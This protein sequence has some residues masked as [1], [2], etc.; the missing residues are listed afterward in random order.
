MNAV[1]LIFELLLSMIYPSYYFT[2]N[3]CC[4]T[5]SRINFISNI[6][7]VFRRFSYVVWCE[8]Y[9]K[10]SKKI[11]TGTLD[12]ENLYFKAKFHFYYKR[13]KLLPH[14]RRCQEIFWHS[15]SSWPRISDVDVA[16]KWSNWGVWFLWVPLTLALGCFIFVSPLSSRVSGCFIFVSPLASHVGMIDFMIMTLLCG[17]LQSMVLRIVWYHNWDICISSHAKSTGG[18]FDLYLASENGGRLITW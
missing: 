5:Q 16:K 10:N 7:Q 14:L 18:T 6:S 11:P 17:T 13:S 4:D 3:S 2:V 9:V 12:L 15:L 1:V 8:E